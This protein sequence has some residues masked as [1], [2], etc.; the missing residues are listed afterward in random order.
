[1]GLMA[2]SPPSPP[3]FIGL[4]MKSVTFEDS[5]F[6]DCYFEDITSS[7]TFFKNCTFIST[8]FYN[9]GLGRGE[10]KRGGRGADGSREGSLQSPPF[11][12]PPPRPLRVQVHQQPPAEQHLPA[13]QGGLPAGLQR[14]QQRL[15][16][17]L[18]Q[19]PGHPGRAAREHRLS[20]AHGQDRPPPHA[21]W[22]L[23]PRPPPLLLPFPPFLSRFPLS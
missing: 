4:K 16:D 10:G 19:L 15:H 11:C 18:C 3:R 21:G 22:A 17:L 1:M 13:Q 7:N 14:R 23:L 9:T 20:A 5:L 2:V 6:E 12:L 8:I